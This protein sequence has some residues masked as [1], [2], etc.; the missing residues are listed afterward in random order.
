MYR[1]L[2]GLLRVRYESLHHHTIARIHVY[3][4]GVFPEKIRPDLKP[5]K[6]LFSFTVSQHE[7]GRKSGVFT[8][9]LVK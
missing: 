5:V 4:E 8:E 6:V 2:C 7:G 1:H 9:R 3:V